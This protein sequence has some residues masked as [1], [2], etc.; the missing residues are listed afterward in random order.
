MTSPV[1]SIVIGILALIGGLMALFNPLAATLTAETMAAWFFCLVG[2]LVLANA[3]WS[4]GAT[5]KILNAFLGIVLLFVGISLLSNPLSGILSLTILV[6]ILFLM[7]GVS[8]VVMAL[9]L[10]I[11]HFWTVALSGAVS[12][13]LAF[14]IFSNLPGSAV[15]TLGVLLGVEL[16]STGISLIVIGA[17]RRQASPA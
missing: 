12:L 1:G 7:G 2:V 14:M 5:T 15:V 16:V 6:A 10:G 17:A 13:V 3:F 9:A 8:K 11:G 4:E